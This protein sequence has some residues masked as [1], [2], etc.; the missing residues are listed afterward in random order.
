MTVIIMLSVV[1]VLQVILIGMQ[2]KKTSYVKT[3]EQ[4]VIVKKL[5]LS[6]KIL[7]TQLQTGMTVEYGEPPSSSDEESKSPIG[8]NK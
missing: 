1:I 5:Q 7:D 3:L 2:I 4:S 6:E 8:F